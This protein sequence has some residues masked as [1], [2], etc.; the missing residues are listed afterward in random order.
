MVLGSRS[1][2]ALAPRCAARAP[3]EPCAEP[4]RASRPGPLAAA[5]RGPA[6]AARPSAAPPAPA[7]SR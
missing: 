7:H 2:S 4:A 6:V 5:R 1:R 3:A